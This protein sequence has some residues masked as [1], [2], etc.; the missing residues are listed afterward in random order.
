VIIA[1]TTTGQTG[2]QC[3][4][5]SDHY[6]Y[7]TTSLV[8]GALVPL[9]LEDA[10]TFST[11]ASLS[12]ECSANVSSGVTAGAMQLIALPVTSITMQ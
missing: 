9:S 2:A 11:T 3:Q 10:I 4:I 8:A 1:N 6:S 12:L 7:S 5:G